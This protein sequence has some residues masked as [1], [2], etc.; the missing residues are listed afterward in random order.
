[1]ARPAVCRHAGCGM[2]IRFVKMTGRDRV[3]CLDRDPADEITTGGT[4]RL[5]TTTAGLRAVV[6]KGDVLNKA[7][8]N[9]ERLYRFHATSCVS[10]RP[11]NPMPEHLRPQVSP[12]PTPQELR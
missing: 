11:H 1:M 3:A 8:A 6:L 10:R 4:V 7:I 2:E 5:L 9:H 12:K